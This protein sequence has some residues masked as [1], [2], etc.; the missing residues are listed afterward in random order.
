MSRRSLSLLMPLGLAGLAGI[1]ISQP[2]GDQK[3]GWKKTVLSR[4]FVTE[5]IS[6]GDIDGDGALDLVAGPFWFKGPEYKEFQRY[7]PGHARPIDT[8]V[9]DSFLSWSED[10]DADGA[11]D[12][13]MVGWPGKEIT[14]YKNP[15]KE[16]GDWKAHRVLDEAA[17]ESPIWVDLNGDGRK[18][19]VCMQGGCFGYASVDW[20]DVT[21][22]W[23]F[24]AISTKRTDSPYIHG[25]GVG[26][27]NGDGRP[28]ILE[29]DGWF[30]QPAE[31]GGDWVYHPTVFA[32]AGGAQMLVFDVDGDGDNDVVTSIQGHSYGLAWYE[33]TGKD[34]EVTFARHEILPEDPAKTGVGG[35]QFS[36]LHAL[37][38]GDFDQDGRMDFVTGKRFWAHNGN[39]PGARDP[40]VV[41]VFYNRNDAGGVRWE[42]ELVDDDSGVGCQVIAVDL[43]GDGRLEIAVGNKKGIFVNAR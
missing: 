36:Q 12:I 32:S 13:L 31:P 30:E 17:T 25:L 6:A 21:K 37:E 16:G 40:A 33:N 24:T 39:D 1:A 5:G 28:D 19:M 8:Y 34:G 18:E 29:K 38:A 22:P 10:L 9:E 26:D 2:A 43:N 42:P 14:F 11:T 41:Y 23:K 3:P 20:S 4:D 35:I 27:L 15:G 7:R